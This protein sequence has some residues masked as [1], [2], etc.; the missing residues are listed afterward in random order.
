MTLTWKETE[1]CE[2]SQTSSGVVMSN[3]RING[4][5]LLIAAC[6]RRAPE[7]PPWA[8]RH[9]CSSSCWPRWWAATSAKKNNN[10]LPF[11]LRMSVA[12]CIFFCIC[13]QKRSVRNHF[14]LI[15]FFSFL[16]LHLADTFCP[17]WLTVIHTYIHSW[18]AVAAILPDD[19]SDMWT[20]FLLL[21][22]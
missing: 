15:F 18:M 4:C 14:L 6:G 20:H 3:F 21:S 22:E 9:C 5:L 16:R 11:V 7:P 19:T 8:V 17:K 10:R 12:F 2:D 1:E 13:N